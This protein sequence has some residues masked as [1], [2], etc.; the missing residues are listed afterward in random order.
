MF[1]MIDVYYYYSGTVLFISTI[2][3]VISLVQTKKVIVVTWFIL[4]LAIIEL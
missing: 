1:W 2:S 4:S 3:L